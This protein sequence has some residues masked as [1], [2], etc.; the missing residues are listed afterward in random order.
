MTL[1]AGV[2][3]SDGTLACADLPRYIN[4]IE[5]GR[6]RTIVLTGTY[7]TNGFCV[8]LMHTLVC[9][10]LPRYIN[11]IEEGR[12]RTIVLTGTYVYVT[13]GLCMTNAWAYLTCTG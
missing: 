6:N 10:D 4:L 5:E 11:L 8:W 7:V 13:N 3:F 9:A 1:C 12:N 2:M